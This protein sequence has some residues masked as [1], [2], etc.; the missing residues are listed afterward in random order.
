MRITEVSLVAVV[1]S[2]FQHSRSSSLNVPRLPFSSNILWFPA[3]EEK[4]ERLT[5]PPKS[6]RLDLQKFR[7]AD[8][9]HFT[10]PF[11]SIEP[12]LNWIRQ[13]Q[14][15]F[16]TK[17]VIDDDDKIYVAGGLLQ[18]TILVGFYASEGAQY[19][20]KTWNEFRSRLFE[21]ALPQRWR[22]TLKAKL[23]ELTIGP[24]KS[25][26]VLSSRARTLQSLINFDTSLSSENAVTYVSD[27]DLAEYVVL[28]VKNETIHGDIAKF[29][30]LDATPFSYSAFENRVA[31]FDE[32]TIRK[33][34]HRAPRTSP[35][36]HAP[37]NSPPDP[38]A[39]RVHAYLDSQDTE[40]FQTPRRPV[41]YKPPKPHGPSSSSAGRPTQP[42]AGRPPFRSTSL[43]AIADSSDSDQPPSNTDYVEVVEAIDSDQQTF[44]DAAAKEDLP[45][46]LTAG[47][48]A[49]FKEIDEILSDNVANVKE[50]ETSV[51]GSEYCSDLGCD[52]FVNTP[53]LP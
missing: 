39:W 37:S 28:G 36:N 44:V 14:I 23:R 40:S 38:V 32:V 21:V 51:C 29:A 19:A 6:T 15:F 16:S 9:P 12:F 24:N 31:S 8:G 53:S 10:G 2:E 3:E 41:D 27:F 11:Q 49:T 20:G 4:Q 50:D 13:L 43:A 45:P 7:I 48:W 17:N 34:T 35:S 46:D 33:T 30:L 47:D 1:E 5:P 26:I 52:P 42:P 18:E 25:F 22:T